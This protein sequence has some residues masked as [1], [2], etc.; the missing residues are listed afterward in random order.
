MIFASIWYPIETIA[1]ICCLKPILMALLSRRRDFGE[2]Y[3]ARSIFSAFDDGSDTKVRAIFSHCGR[4]PVT[5][6]VHV[7]ATY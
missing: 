7:L 6:P 3:A 4:L 2:K 5:L 1:L